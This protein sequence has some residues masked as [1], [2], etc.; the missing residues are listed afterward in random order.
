MRN[1]FLILGDILALLLTTLLGFVTHGETDFS[2]LPRFLAAFVPLTLAWFLLAPWLGLFQREIVLDLK[3]TWRVALVLLF[4][5]PLAVTVRG[6][7][8]GSDAK[9]IF[10][11]VFGVTSAMGLLLWRG[12]YSF[13]RRKS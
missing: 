2:F 11:L 9:P 3:Q 1:Y 7:L 13:L 12:S 4:A 10:V 8:L 6:A 5:A